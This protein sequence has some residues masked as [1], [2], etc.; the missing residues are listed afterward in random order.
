MFD[1]L[2]MVLSGLRSVAIRTGNRK[3]KCSYFGWFVLSHRASVNECLRYN[4]HGGRDCVWLFDVEHRIWIL[5]N[6]HPK[7]SEKAEKSIPTK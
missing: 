7:T 1:K 3:N 4:C 6:R 5:Q 2:K